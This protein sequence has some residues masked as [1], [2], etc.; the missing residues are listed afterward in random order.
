MDLERVLSEEA[1]MLLYA[2]YEFFVQ[3]DSITEYASLGYEKNFE[4]PGTVFGK[5]KIEQELLSLCLCCI[6]AY[7][8]RALNRLSEIAVFQFYMFFLGFK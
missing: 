6:C 1:Y 2:R 3:A 7:S 8:M 5:Y 4:K